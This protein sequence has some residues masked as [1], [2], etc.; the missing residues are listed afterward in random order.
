[1]IAELR[2]A[3]QFI[4]IFILIGSLEYPVHSTI[5][6]YS[7][8]C[9]SNDAKSTMSEDSYLKG[10]REEG[11]EQALGY[12]VGSINYLQEGKIKFMDLIGYYKEDNN[13]K[14]VFR[15]M[16]VFFE[17][18][19]G[20]SNF[21]SEGFLSDSMTISSKNSIGFQDFVENKS[22]NP[23]RK[24]Y[25]LKNNY[26]FNQIHINA[27]VKIGHD[28]KNDIDFNFAY[29][30]SIFKGVAEISNILRW[31]KRP[32]ANGIDWEQSALMKGNIS[33]KN[34]FSLLD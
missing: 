12:Q 18:E 11:N 33:A 5:I 6:T 25:V 7:L 13:S 15:N 2:Y 20:I 26:T 19:K 4:M 3:I 22:I 23:N 8:K 28:K 16:D 9:E 29:N 24:F 27:D 21:Y 1:M 14:K 34:N 17:G 10:T 30:A 32:G 31:A